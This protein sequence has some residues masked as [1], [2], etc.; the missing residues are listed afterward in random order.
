MSSASFSSAVLVTCTAAGFLGASFGFS[1]GFSISGSLSSSSSSSSESFE[2]SEKA[3][4]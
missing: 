4:A 1:F 2:S 3:N